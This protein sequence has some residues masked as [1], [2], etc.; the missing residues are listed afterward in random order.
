LGHAPPGSGEP[1]APSPQGKQSRFRIDSRYI[2]PLF[3]TCILI[4]GEYS[5]GFLE[6]PWKTGLAILTSMA[7]EMVL[8]RLITGQWP[9]VA[10]AYITGIS[11][12]ILI[13]STFLW[14][15]ALCSAMA[16]TSKYAL[17][18]GGRHIWNPS[19]FAI[20]LMFLL[21]PDCAVS[22]GQQWGNE[23]WPMLIIWAL[24]CLIVYRFNRLNITLTYAASFV[25]FAYLRSE[26][27][28]HKFLTDVAPITGPMYQ[29]YV[30]F[31]ITDPK[32]TTRS[33]WSQCLVAFLIAVVEMSLRLYGS[34]Y[35]ATWAVHA[36]YFALF[37]VGPIANLIEIFTSPRPQAK[38][39][40]TGVT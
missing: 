33:K 28:G 9:Q 7:V 38:P 16:I 8:G 14:P 13:R 30:F 10:S 32:T 5:Y 39:A 21:V 26:L 12:G 29:L 17:R 1:K 2:P 35:G 18:V 40:A 4:G 23:V 6:S 3:I 19:N 36:P 37:L 15:Y 25:A 31:M 34:Y 11:V 24:G 20:S 27:T 22:L